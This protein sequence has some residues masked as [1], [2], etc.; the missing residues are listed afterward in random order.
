M[1]IVQNSLKILLVNEKKKAKNLVASSTFKAIENF[2][3]DLVGN[4]KLEK[5]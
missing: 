4:E 1:K 5:L 2:K 3:E